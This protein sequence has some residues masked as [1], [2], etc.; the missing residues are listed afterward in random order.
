MPALWDQP[1]SGGSRGVRGSAWSSALRRKREKHKIKLMTFFLPSLCSF[2]ITYSSCSSVWAGTFWHTWDLQTEGWFHQGNEILQSVSVT[3]AAQSSFRHRWTKQAE[4][5]TQ[6]LVS[7]GKHAHEECNKSPTQKRRETQQLLLKSIVLISLDNITQPIHL[8]HGQPHNP[9][10]LLLIR[11]CQGMS[12]IK[13]AGD[14]THA[15][16]SITDAAL[17]IILHLV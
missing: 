11:P 12:V 15:L 1:S 8:R 3:E 17:I 16:K 9:R 6:R 10:L 5:D 2:M 13:C 14:F 7:T 4:C